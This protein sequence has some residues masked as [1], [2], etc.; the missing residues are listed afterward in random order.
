MNVAKYVCAEPAETRYG[1]AEPPLSE[2][3]PML[4]TAPISRPLRP[5]AALLTLI[6]AVRPVAPARTRNPSPA[7]TAALPAAWSSTVSVAL[8]VC[9]LLEAFGSLAVKV[10]VLEPSSVDVAAT[11]HAWLALGASVPELGVTLPSARCRRQRRPKGR[12]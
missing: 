1:T 11:V 3:P 12:N 8:T 10:I 9:G 4:G 5:P 7:V 6:V 2:P